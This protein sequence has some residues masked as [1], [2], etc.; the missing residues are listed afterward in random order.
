LV[1]IV[2]TSGR[3]LRLLSLLQT[4]RDWTGSELADRLEV[5]Q[6][7]IRN[8]IDRLRALGYPVHAS[9]GPIG[10]Y[11]LEAGATLPPLLLE[12]DEAVAVAIGLRSATGGAVAGIEE[13]SLRALAKLEQ[14][15]PPR[16][17]ARVNTLQTYTLHVRDTRSR[18]NPSVDPT[19]LTE[20]AAACRDRR[21]LRFDYAD[22]RGEATQR[23][24]Q[25]HR[26]VNWGQRWYL[27]AW[28]TDRSDWRTFRVD[29]VAP[30][31]SLGTRFTA[32]DLS[33]AAVE[34]L[35]SRGVPH[36]ARRYQARVIVHASAAALAE[37]IGP[38]AG[39]VTA[40]DD[41]ICRLDTGAD[42]LEMMAVYL[43]TLG[44]D[45]TVADPPELI[46]HIRALS[47]RYA[48]AAGVDPGPPA[49]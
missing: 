11:R 33:D 17:R 37:R 47:T 14:V 22:R 5:S 44:V 32:R 35:V 23:R 28:D 20:L 19:L 3:L 41:A 25:P 29:R 7:T 30:G 39:T 2:T 15:L 49:M 27:V 46:D 1:A 42:S 13:T 36:A 6:R 34:A 10:G 4:P 45:F 16:L 21:A 9:R 26:V 12:D 43:G 31:V 38:N 8:D 40:I 24:V 18:A 48:R